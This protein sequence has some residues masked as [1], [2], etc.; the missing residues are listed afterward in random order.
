ML[1]DMSLRV[2]PVDARSTLIEIE[3]A[4]NGKALDTLLSQ[5]NRAMIDR[6]FVAI[7]DELDRRARWQYPQTPETLER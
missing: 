2:R 5:Q 6:L 4:S 3:V 1:S 7:Q